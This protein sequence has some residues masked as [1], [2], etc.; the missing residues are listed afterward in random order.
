MVEGC[1]GSWLRSFSPLGA[2]ELWCSRLPISC[3][4]Y[5]HTLWWHCQYV[6]NWFN[7]VNSWSLQVE[8]LFSCGLV[9]QITRLVQISFENQRLQ[10]LLHENKKQ[11]KCVNKMEHPTKWPC[12]RIEYTVFHHIWLKGA[13]YPRSGLARLQLLYNWAASINAPYV[14]GDMNSVYFAAP[15]T[16][17]ILI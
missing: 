7:Y 12:R 16:H 8:I 2:A 11:K 1:A 5:H 3:H 4:K 10:W 17:D 14:L 9:H 13:Q 15:S 6:C